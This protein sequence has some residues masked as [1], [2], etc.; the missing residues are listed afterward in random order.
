VA[1][2]LTAARRW[3]GAIFVIGLAVAVTAALASTGKRRVTEFGLPDKAGSTHEIT[4]GPD[5]NLWVTQQVQGKIVR[6]AP[7]GRQQAFTMPDNTMPHGIRFDRHGHLW[8]TMEATDEIA[9]LDQLGR[10]LR[11]FPIRRVVAG[12]H[13]LAIAPDGA[14]WWTGKEGDVIGRLDPATGRMR[15][16][17]L[18]QGSQPIYIASGCGAM[19]FTELNGS[20]IGRITNAGHITEYPTPTPSARPI[21]VAPRHC[22]VWFSEEAGHH[23]GVLDPRTARI[24]EYPLPNPGDE[25]AALAFDRTGSLWLQFRTPDAF[26]R[27]DAHK[28]VHM[29]ALPTKNAVMHRII[30]GPGGNMW[31]T[32][33]MTDKVGYFTP[34]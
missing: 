14:V 33:L 6:I 12:P 11:R 17:Q 29:L 19:Y 15:V 5:G 28:R 23:F 24:K 7:D 4:V 2:R 30:L 22:K 34:R 3:I 18:P 31:F 8:I 10:I 13:G 25:L 27:V 9:E 26:G 20:R 1:G 32:E 21:A 16:F